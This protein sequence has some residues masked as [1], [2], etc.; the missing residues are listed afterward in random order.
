MPS[1]VGRSVFVVGGTGLLGRAVAT[2]LLASGW[3]VRLLVRNVERAQQLLGGGFDY[4]SGD[5]SDE[6]ALERGLDG[7]SA[8]HVSLSAVGTAEEIDR[9]EHRGTARVAQLAA[10][11]GSIHLT[12]VSG[13]LV[14]EGHL[15]FPS[16][17]AKFQ[18]ERAIRESGVA[19][20]IFK[21]TYF[22]DTLPRHVQGRWAIVLGR[23][24]HPLHMI[25]ASDFSG[26]VSRALTTP[27]A[28]NRTFVVHGP[29][30]ITI[31][32]ALRLYCSI[33]RPGTRVITV[34]V[35][36]MRVVD[37]LF[38]GGRLD[39]TRDLMTLM[40]RV[41]EQGDPVETTRV[42]GMPTTTVREWCL[43]TR[44]EAS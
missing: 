29:E 25:A 23:R 42:L 21:P 22:I 9:V 6:R 16:H 32:E 38:M 44:E 1:G 3:R 24:P 19:Y 11:L 5:V 33:P 14:S 41:G 43:A 4:V 15:T 37:R 39:Q 27:E 8:V 2:P 28:W 36:I 34:P 13:G 10:R 26:M 18:A 12:Y 35:G 30:G 17:R 20:T 31:A 7:C 40:S